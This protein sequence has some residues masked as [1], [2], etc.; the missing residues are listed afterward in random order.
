MD[1]KELLKN[2]YQIKKIIKDCE[3]MRKKNNRMMK[4][5]NNIKLKK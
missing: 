2:I 4:K 1:K 3:K 5:L